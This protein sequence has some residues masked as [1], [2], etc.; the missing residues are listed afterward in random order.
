MTYEQALQKINNRLRFG[1][2]PG[3]ERVEK[4]LSLLGNPQEKL[5]FVHVAGTNGKGSTC[6]LIS[7]ALTECGIK[8]GLYTSPYVI[9]FRERF[10]I[11]GEMISEEELI[12][13]V[14]SMLPFV[15]KMEQAGE[16]ITEFEFITALALNWFSRKKCGIVVLEVGLGG[17]FDAT[18]VI[19]TPDVAAIMSI[20]LDHTEI[21]GDTIEKIAFEKAGIIKSGGDVVLYPKQSDGVVDIIREI[22]IER[23]ANLNVPDTEN[24]KKIYSS[25]EG[26]EFSY[27]DIN[28]KTP[29]LGEHQIYN[30]ITAYET[31]KILEAKGVAVSDEK[32]KFGFE[33]AFIPARMEILSKSPLI[34]MDGGH[35]PGCALALKQAID[36]FLPNKKLLAVMGMMADKDSRSALDIIGPLFSKIITVAPNNPRSLSA[37]ELAETARIV[38]PNCVPCK[39]IAEV[40]EVSFGEL[41]NYDALIICGSFFL[42]GEI[43][44]P[45]INKFRKI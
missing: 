15:E 17:R 11:G 34:I 24:V 8:V 45:I 6:T 2:K 14:E 43:R 13:E 37:D 29:F 35:N 3:L 33:K 18:N 25:I 42:A 27:N 7:S 32:I 21:L 4:L 36:E 19:D 16:A 40:I 38:C 39:S 12:R 9:D 5:K 20:S 23:N 22:C 41:A 28:L 44:E 31:L 30:A 26:T 10:K 1:I